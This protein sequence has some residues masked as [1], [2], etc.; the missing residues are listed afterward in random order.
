MTDEELGRIRSDLSVMRQAMGLH[1][2]FGQGMLT[3]GLL[4]TL[5]AVGAA[6]FSWLVEDDWL[7]LVPF[8]A[9]MVLVPVGLYLR[10]SRTPGLSPEIIMQVIMSISTY[11][12][13]WVAGFSYA[14]AKFAG[15]AIGSR[16]TAF[17]YTTGLGLLLAFTLILVLTALKSRERYYCFGLAVSTLLAGMLFPLLGWPYSYSLAHC[18]MAVGYLTAVAIQWAQLREAVA[19]HAAN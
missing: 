11:A 17:M 13:V 14:I 16:R 12:V 8:T 15:P 1:L 19:N 5:A 2:S 3:F 18:F 9:I 10:S 4:L 6:A 7:Q